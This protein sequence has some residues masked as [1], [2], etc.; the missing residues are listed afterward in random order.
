MGLL[1]LPITNF[2]DFNYWFSVVVTITVY[3]LPLLFAL[4]FIANLD[5]G[6]KF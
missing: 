5:L 6:K 3:T 2:E 1:Y 4:A